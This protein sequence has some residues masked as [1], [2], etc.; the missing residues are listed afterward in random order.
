MQINWKYSCDSD[1]ITVGDDDENFSAT[2]VNL[3]CNIFA[4]LLNYLN[5]IFAEKKKQQQPKSKHS[6][7]VQNNLI[8]SMRTL[9]FKIGVF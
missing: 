6:I 9:H 8:I 4:E 2:P 1:E 7:R 3:E 5:F